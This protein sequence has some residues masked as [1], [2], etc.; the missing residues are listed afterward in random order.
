MQG[1]RDDNPYSNNI[2]NIKDKTHTK[3][4][5]L[6]LDGSMDISFSGTGGYTECTSPDVGAMH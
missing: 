5:E 1:L 4:E 6:D 2:E 3:V